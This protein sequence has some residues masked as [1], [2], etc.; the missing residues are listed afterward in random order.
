MKTQTQKYLISLI[1]FLAFSLN[2]IA[3][4]TIKFTVSKNTVVFPLKFTITA[5][6][7]R[8]F[9]VVS[10]VANCFFELIDATGRVQKSVRLQQGNNTI[11]TSSLKAGL[12]IY[13][14]VT[15]VRAVSGKWVKN[16][17]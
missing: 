14:A 5:T 1:C 16:N 9:T 12:Y 2:V 15:D 8:P 6:E 4:E 3:Q 7:G 10:E 11:N 13:K 17:N